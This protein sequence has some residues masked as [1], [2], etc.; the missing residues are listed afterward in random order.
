[1]MNFKKR[2]ILDEMNS[3]NWALLYTFLFFFSEKDRKKVEK[4]RLI[5][6][7]V[8]YLQKYM[9]SR[10]HLPYRLAKY[11]DLRWKAFLQLKRYIRLRCQR[12]L[13]RRFHF[14]RRA[15]SSIS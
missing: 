3:E 9:L 1:M 4:S 6:N 12:L 5:S 14:I 11:E 15:V 13:T 2:T 10:L 8:S 7:S